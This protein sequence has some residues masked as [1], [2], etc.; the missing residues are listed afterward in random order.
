MQLT[1]PDEVRSLPLEPARN[2]FADFLAALAGEG[3]MPITTEESFRITEV[4]LMA[5][6]AQD[7]GRVVEV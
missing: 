6:E 4:A 2:I 1:T 5:R 7:T 3:E